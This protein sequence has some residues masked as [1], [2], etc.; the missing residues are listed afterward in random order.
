MD[1][2][3]TCPLGAIRLTGLQHHLFNGNRAFQAVKVIVAVSVSAGFHQHKVLRPGRN[4]RF[5]PQFPGNS[6]QAVLSCLRCASGIFPCAG[7]T[8]FWSPAGQK[9][10]AL[11]IINPHTDHQP[12]LPFPPGCATAVDPSG[13]VAVLIVNIIP[14]H[15]IGLPKQIGFS[16]AQRAR[17][18]NGYS[19]F[20]KKL[21]A[22]NCQ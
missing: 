17:K 3:K 6:L 11:S 13:S 16:I 10:I 15:N 19:A 18:G 5:L 8:L 20:S 1:L 21:P 2:L 9:D 14:F 12:V 7:K 4:S 22:G